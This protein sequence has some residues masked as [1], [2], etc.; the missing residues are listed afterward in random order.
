MDTALFLKELSRMCW[1]MRKTSKYEYGCGKC[2]FNPFEG[3]FGCN[4]DSLAENADSVIS[5]VS[6]WS[7]EHPIKTNSERFEEVFG[8]NTGLVKIVRNHYNGKIINFTI[9]KKALLQWLDAPY[10]EP[11]DGDE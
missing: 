4:F 9:H 3:G 7:A 10:E 8:S 2:P 1:A 6:Q 11:K 5:I